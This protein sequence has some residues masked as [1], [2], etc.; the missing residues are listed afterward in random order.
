MNYTY[1]DTYKLTG[2]SIV[3]PD[4]GSKTIAYTYGE[5]GNRLS[6]TEDGIVT[7]YNYDNNDRLTTENLQLE[8]CNYSYDDNGNTLSKVNPTENIAYTYDYNNRLISVEDGTDVIE[9]AYDTDGMRVRKSVN[10]DVINYLLDKNRDYAQV[11]KEYNDSDST[12]VSYIYGDDL[13][14]QNRNGMKSYYHYDGQ[15]STRSLT[16]ELSEVTDTYTYDAFGL[17]LALSGST[18]NNYLYTGEQNDP[19]VGFYYLRARYYNSSIGRFLT[20][21]TWPGMQFEPM[22][23][24]RY[25]YCHSNP[26]GNW[27]PSGKFTII[28]VTCGWLIANIMLNMIIDI[29]MDILGLWTETAEWNGSIAFA[30]VGDGELWSYAGIGVGVGYISSSEGARGFYVLTLYGFSLSFEMKGGASIIDVSLITPMVFANDAKYLGGP[31]L[32]L[33][34]TV[35]VSTIPMYSAT[36]T[37]MGFGKIKNSSIVG[38]TEGLWDIGIDIM[39][40]VSFAVP[41]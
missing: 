1:D 31:A 40:G 39:A 27:D 22:S 23:L 35:A 18:E 28:E 2:E 6:K 5:V 29:S 30:S 34:V 17:L 41:K 12:R 37:Q 21:D 10:G 16:N 26:I 4:L 7:S 11:L 13:I 14:S 32:W 9:Y 24:H 33:S 8:T 19:N 25:L 3:D 38:K 15:L 36:I 20:Q